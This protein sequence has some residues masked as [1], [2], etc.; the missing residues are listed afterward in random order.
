MQLREA[1]VLVA[2]RTT[3]R[4][5][6]PAGV[7]ITTVRGEA[8]KRLVLPPSTQLTRTSPASEQAAYQVAYQVACRAR[9]RLAMTEQA[10]SSDLLYCC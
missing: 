5:R 7:H 4:G 8:T 10:A 9:D 2:A 1:G 3:G 6:G